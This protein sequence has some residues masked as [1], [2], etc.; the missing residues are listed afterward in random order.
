MSIS[1]RHD[2]FLLLAD[3]EGSTRLSSR[4][5]QKVTRILSTALRSL[6][7]EYA[8][9]VALPLRQ[10]YGDEMAGLFVRPRNMYDVIDAIRE[11]TRPVVR[12]RFVVTSGR[13][14]QPADDVSVVGGAI[15]KKAHERM[16]ES[17]QRSR[18]V[19]IAWEIGPPFERG[20]LQALSSMV[21]SRIDDLTDYRYQIWRLLR[22]GHTQTEV[23]RKLRRHTQS[24][25]SATARGH[26]RSLI[27]GESA[28]RSILNRL[29]T[30]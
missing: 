3:I 5:M 9:D 11:A 21:G 1:T 16:N 30:R 10:Q 15:F 12:V 13:V 7:S 19:G 18:G 20:V 29:S 8:D 27:E 14:G 23:A 22:D 17:K 4:D 24:V 26:I 28:I 6:S 2:S 25:S